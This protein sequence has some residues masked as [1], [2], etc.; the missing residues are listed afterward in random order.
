MFTYGIEN[1]NTNFAPFH[2]NRG[3]V[4]LKVG[5]LHAAIKDCSKAID[6]LTPKCKSNG[7]QRAKAH[8]R[9]ATGKTLL[10]FFNLRSLCYN[11]SLYYNTI[12]LFLENLFSTALAALGLYSNA[13]G[14]YTEANRIL[15]DNE[16]I[17]KDME[18]VRDMLENEE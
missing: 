1:V 8:M 13:L 10:Y 15:P 3:A 7:P 6:L 5:N 17:K 11:I 16:G 4:N 2:N 14:E 18:L 9:R 12:F